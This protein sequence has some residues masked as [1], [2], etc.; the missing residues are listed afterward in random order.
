[1][2]MSHNQICNQNFDFPE[3]GKADASNFGHDSQQKE[4]TDFGGT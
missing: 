4:E 1:M 3:Y 2:H